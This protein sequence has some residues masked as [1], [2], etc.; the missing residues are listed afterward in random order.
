MRVKRL[1][2]IVLSISST[3]V[4]NVSIIA[5]VWLLGLVWL[6]GAW[7]VAT[8]FGIYLAYRSTFPLWM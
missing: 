2:A 8:I 6:G 7:I 3:I 4:L 5:A 1:P